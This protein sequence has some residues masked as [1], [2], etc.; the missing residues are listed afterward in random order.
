M[1]S[2]VIV[3]TAM[4]S[5]VV[6]LGCSDGGAGRSVTIDEYLR[7]VERVNASSETRIEAAGH[8]VQELDA[9]T[10][11][12]DLRAAFA[13]V[14][15][16]FSSI[17]RDGRRDLDELK[18]PSQIADRHG[19]MIAGLEELETAFDDVREQVRDATTAQDLGKV[20]EAAGQSPA[21][22]AAQKRVRKACDSLQAAADANAIDVD[23]RCGT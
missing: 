23:L 22:A 19:E 6:A 9:S 5:I 21:I 12:E 13:G 14:Y 16:E 11:F 4:L 17:T 3:A 8:G 18:P 10:P 20:V 7:E 1:V 15:D 2:R